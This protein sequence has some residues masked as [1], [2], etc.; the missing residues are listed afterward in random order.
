MGR[1]QLA[2]VDAHLARCPQ[3]QARRVAE[4]AITHSVREYAREQERALPPSVVAGIRN[5]IEPRAAPS[6][7]DT[8]RAALRP[9][10]A[11]PLAAAVALIL[12]VGLSGRHGASVPAT[13]DPAYYV[14]NHA[15]MA[16]TAPF[17]DAAPP[18]IVLT[19]TDETR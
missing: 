4:E 11:V 3:C 6:R 9:I 18:A 1:E 10:Y 5:G 13:I 7:W 16:E 8:L 12:Y 14:E 2:T 19:S 15:V 17:G